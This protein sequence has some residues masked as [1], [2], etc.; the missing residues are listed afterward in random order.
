MSRY[1]VV[2]EAFFYAENSGGENDVF[3]KIA[4]W[5]NSRDEKRR[6]I[7]FKLVEPFFISGTGLF[8][9]VFLVNLVLPMMTQSM[10]F[11]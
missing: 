7:C 5:I 9:L 10:N 11:L 8:L 1:I 3:E 4:S 2:E 6:A